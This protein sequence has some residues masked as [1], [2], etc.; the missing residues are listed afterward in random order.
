MNPTAPPSV[1]ETR[2]T[3]EMEAPPTVTLRQP[4]A[5]PSEVFAEQ[6]RIQ[7]ERKGWTQ[8]QLADRLGKLG[9]DVHQTTI[10]KWET[11]ERRIS[12]DEALVIS[13]ALDVSPAYMIAGSYLDGTFSGPSIALSARTPPVSARKMLMWLRGQQPLWGQDEK[14]YHTEVAP[15]EWLA[16]QRAG[17]MELLR[18]V[19]ELVDAWA[20]D[21]RETALELVEAISD[22]LERQRRALGREMSKE[23]RRQGLVGA[24]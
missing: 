2:Q 17:V 13:V 24:G 22:E 1:T 12:L 16:M 9:F 21:D 6:M 14:R 7:R 18:G 19:Q 15:D 8:K 4:P 10:G 3:P 20:G 23:T 5:R 11:G